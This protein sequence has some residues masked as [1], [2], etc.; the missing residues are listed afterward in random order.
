[1]EVEARKWVSSMNS[2][3]RKLSELPGIYRNG[4][5][6]DALDQL[7][8][9]A[10]AVSTKNVP[11]PFKSQ[12]DD[13]ITA[14]S[15]AGLSMDQVNQ[16]KRLYEKHV[17]LG[18][19]KLLAPDS[20]KQAT[21]LDTAIRTFQFDKAKELGFKNIADISKQTQLSRFIVD[22]LGD[23]L[24]DANLL[25]SIS[26]TDAILLGDVS[27]NGLGAFLT[28]RVFASKTVQA[29]VAK[30]LNKSAPES[31]ITPVSEVTDEAIRRGISPQG[32]LALP[33]G[34]TGTPTTF[35]KGTIP[36]APQGGNFEFT[37]RQGVTP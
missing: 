29:K 11:A 32:Q 1:M 17:K 10:D 5:I 23:K 33:S 3:D 14:N 2:M 18:Y 16:V 31:I 15:N 20:V 7:A 36:V 19:S 4:A 9:K 30:W 25:N 35:G 26:L 37:G 13:L 21:N 12:V 8:S 22:K 6:D 24:V 27:P 34:Q 28:R